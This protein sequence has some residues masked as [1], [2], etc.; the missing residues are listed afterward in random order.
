MSPFRGFGGRGSSMTGRGYFGRGGYGHP[1]LY[2][3]PRERLVEVAP[4]LAN[5]LGN[6]TVRDFA[7]NG[8]TLSATIDVDGQTYQGSLDLSQL[9]S[10]VGDRVAAYHAQLHQLAAQ[11]AAQ[12]D[13]SP[14]VAQDA[15]VASGVAQAA[16]AEQQAAL[17]LAGVALVGSLVDKHLAKHDAKCA[18]WFD[19]I[20]DAVS[21]AAKGV[22]HAGEAGYHGITHTWKKLK[23]PIQIAATAF[24]GPAAGA[25]AGTVIDAANGDIGSKQ[26][27]AQVRANAAVNPEI[28]KNLTKATAAAAKATAAY[29]VVDTIGN[30]AQGDPAAGQQVQQLLTSA[31][32]GDPSAQSALELAQVLLSMG[33]PQ[34]T[35]AAA[36]AVS[37]IASS[38]RHEA[39]HAAANA[40]G[41]G[42]IIGYIKPH[43]GNP[44]QVRTFASV[45][46]ADDW[47]GQWLGLPYA[48]HYVAYY[49]KRDPSFPRP[50]NE[51]FGKTP[52]WR[53]AQVSGWLPWLTGAAGFAA[54][55][56]EPQIA[57]LARS[58]WD[59]LK[60]V[61]PHPAPR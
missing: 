49:D 5:P 12:P 21:S 57:S 37:G 61:V 36:T 54:G 29:H 19:S 3:G 40:G 31:A 56:F 44:P 18:G 41:E 33:G 53:E 38:L 55:Y 24:G 42:A 22:Y 43:E 25:L 39:A 59:K 34:A 14:A 32:D 30:A 46:D 51:A 7:L 9:A 47:F 11:S 13:G 35:Q 16:S 27:L 1:G 15:V 50:L 52:P 28:Q 48:F 26:A 58:G 4:I 60:A 17:T 2:Y 20:T 10:V 6:V 23:A 45:D 8:N